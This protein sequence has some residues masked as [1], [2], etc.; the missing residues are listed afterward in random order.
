MHT[1][2]VYTVKKVSLVNSGSNGVNI[3]CAQEKLAEVG[4]RTAKGKYSEEDI[5]K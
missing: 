5:V 3:K 4:L 2:L 1:L